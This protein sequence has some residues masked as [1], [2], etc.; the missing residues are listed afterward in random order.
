MW[1]E[2]FI[3]LPKIDKSLHK[4]VRFIY[5]TLDFIFFMVTASEKGIVLCS[6]SN[7]YCSCTVL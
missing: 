4:Y 5:L 7:I 6:K 1:S 2:K 3:G